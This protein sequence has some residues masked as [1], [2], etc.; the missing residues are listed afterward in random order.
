[1]RWQ[2]GDKKWQN[3]MGVADE[4]ATGGEDV[5]KVGLRSRPHTLTQCSRPRAE[6]AADVGPL[7]PQ[8][9]RQTRATT[10]EFG[11]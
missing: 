6:V 8:P 2:D 9:L 4:V 3:C 11:A 10:G 5:T 1:M 7:R